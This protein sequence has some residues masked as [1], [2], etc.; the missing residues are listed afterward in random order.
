MPVRNSEKVISK[1]IESI[2]N[3]TY[4]EFEFLILDDHSTDSTYQIMKEYENLDKRVK[5]FKNNRNIGLTSSLNKLISESKYEYIARQDS[6][7]V[8]LENRFAVQKDLLDTYNYDF[9]ITR[10]RIKNTS[11]KIPKFSIYLP[12]K[13]VIKYKNPFI[14]GTLMIKKI[15]LL[16]RG[17]YNERFYYAQD[18]E[19][20]WDLLKQK[21]K[22][23]FI[24]EIHYELNMENNISSLK[25]TE[26]K[27]YMDCVKNNIV[28]DKLVI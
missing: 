21:K 3:Q 2:L 5:V 4:G 23:A 25:K 9:C 11:K 1:S 17:S 6:D 24:N 22:Y 19:L 26:Q 20:F 18:Y 10:A 27:Y 13:I 8:S 28:P 7:D 12:D 15:V 16:E 14:H